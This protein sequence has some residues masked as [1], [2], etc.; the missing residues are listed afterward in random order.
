M[1]KKITRKIGLQRRSELSESQRLFK[2][3]QIFEKIK[4]DI[5][6]ADVVGCYV[7]YQTEVDTKEILSYCFKNQKKI[8]VP[9]VNGNTLTFYEIHAFSDL[10]EGAFHIMEPKTSNIIALREIDCMIVPIVAYDCN[11]NRCGYGKGF[12]DSVL[13]ECKKKI[14]IAFVEQQ[15]N[16]I[17]CETHDVVLD[18]VISA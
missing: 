18:E 16:L 2:S 10:T 6:C 8:C 9:K 1:D 11:C 3:R 4:K 14:G 12:Y 17:D 15:V 13:R 5:D 7:S